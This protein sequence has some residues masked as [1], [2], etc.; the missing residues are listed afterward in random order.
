[1]LYTYMIKK[2]EKKL[3]F[4]IFRKLGIPIFLII[5][6]ALIFIIILNRLIFKDDF[7]FGTCGWHL[8][9]F[10][11]SSSTSYGFLCVW[12]NPMGKFFAK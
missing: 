5:C 8:A 10:F 2:I 1:M 4:Q 6:I 3:E 11:P 7:Y 12:G 9:F